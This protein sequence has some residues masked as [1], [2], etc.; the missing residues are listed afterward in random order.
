MIAYGSSIQHIVLQPV[1]GKAIPVRRG[2]VMRIRQVLGEQCVD[3]NSFCL[4]DYKEYMDVSVCRPTVGFRPRK[5]DIIYSNPPRFRPMLGILE[6]S[7][8]CVTDI[9]GKSCHAS[10]FEIAQGLP[11][12]TNC[13]D[14]ISESI[15]E[16]GL[17]PDDVHHSLNLWMNSEW[18]SR[19]RYEIVRN[20]A[21]AGDYVD[22]LACFDQLMVPTIC[23]SG[24]TMLTSNFS[25]KPI[26]VEVFA[27]SDATLGL[28]DRIME[29]S[30]RYRTQRTVDQ[31][32]VKTIRADRRL[33]AVPGFEPKFVNYPIEVSEI[34][35]SLSEEEYRAAEQLVTTGFGRDVPDVVRKGFML[36]RGGRHP[37]NRD[38]SRIPLAWL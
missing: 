38:W 19:G 18:D 30:G 20:T 13:Q 28:V 7:D 4:A 34:E 35:V 22:L 36:W 37:R 10:L 11:V 12:H 21:R 17:T 26:E 3:F 31:F 8:D 14:T 29:R 5:L 6:M 33:T 23:G 24:D 16:Y 25:F 27:A 32:R 15:A 2:E 9:L 1:S